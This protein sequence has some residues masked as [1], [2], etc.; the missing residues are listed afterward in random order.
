MGCHGRVC[1]ATSQLGLPELNL[2]LIPGFGGTQRLPRLVGIQK[3]LQMMLTSA[4]VKGK[5]ALKLKLVD[6]LVDEKDVIKVLFCYGSIY[7]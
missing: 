1:T 6:D 5:E 7:C 3:A 2:G 4:P